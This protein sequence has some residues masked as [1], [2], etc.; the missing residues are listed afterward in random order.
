MCTL[1][2]SFLRTLPCG[3]VSLQWFEFPHNFTLGKNLLPWLR[4]RENETSVLINTNA[5]TQDPGEKLKAIESEMIRLKEEIRT[6]KA[7]TFLY[8]YVGFLDK[9]ATTVMWGSTEFIL[10]VQMMWKELICQKHALVLTKDQPP[11][12][13]MIIEAWT[14][15][16]KRLYGKQVTAS[17]MHT[18]ISSYSLWLLLVINV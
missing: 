7:C 15:E 2:R 1:T 8:F 5:C 3:K 11:K 6:L 14:T 13:R 18:C 12:E 10:V 9:P 16:M 17:V 4:I